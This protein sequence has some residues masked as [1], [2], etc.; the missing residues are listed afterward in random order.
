[1]EPR[2]DDF[3]PQA[4]CIGQDGLEYEDFAQLIL[5]EP[6]DCWR[7]KHI[8]TARRR[9]TR[10]SDIRT[11]IKA[12]DEGGDEVLEVR[13]HARA[14]LALNPLGRGLIDDFVVNSRTP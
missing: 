4:P 5:G 7:N 14:N 11:W 9:G 6:K 2:R 13:R 10:E 8:I 1:M 3:D 12:F